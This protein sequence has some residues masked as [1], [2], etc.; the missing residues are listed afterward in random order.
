MR[1]QAGKKR[2]RRILAVFLLL[3]LLIL[4]FYLL[5]PFR[6]NDFV[7]S[8]NMNLGM[9]EIVAA[10]EMTSGQH[11]LAG[12]GGSLD[13]WLHMRYKTAEHLLEAQLP[14]VQSA[15]VSLDFPGTIAIDIVERIEVAYISIPDGYV[16]IDKYGVAMRIGVNAPEGIPLIEGITA[17]SLSLGQQLTVDV[18]DA[19]NSAITLMGAIIDADADTR[20]DIR[21]LSLI[22]SIRPVSGKKLYLSI[23][24]PES[25]ENLLVMA[26]TGRDQYD[27]MTWLRLALDQGVLENRGRGILDLTGGRRIFTPE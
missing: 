20:T 17:R 22:G 3:V 4:L 14:L 19:L 9:D 25:G 13:H 21:L 1:R 11:L 24:L 8:G 10:S 27:D 7:I 6:L 12:L 5:P 18:P 23:R 16:M 15:H 26:E 2:G